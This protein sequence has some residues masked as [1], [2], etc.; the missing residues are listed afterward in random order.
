MT[1]PTPTRMLAAGMLATLIRDH[2]CGTACT[3][4]ARAGDRI[5]QLR[6]PY[7]TLDLD[8]PAARRLVQTMYASEARAAMKG[9][10]R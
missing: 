2:V 8:D 4:T 1:R 5:I 3:G 7:T 10:P 9:H 6:C